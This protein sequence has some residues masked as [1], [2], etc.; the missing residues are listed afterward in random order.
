MNLVVDASAILAILFDEPDAELHLSK[1]LTAAKAW[2]SPVNWWEVQARMHSKYGAVG[3]AKSASWMESMGIVVEP[4]TLPQAKIA[5]AAFAKYHGRPAKL[6]MGDCFAYALAQ[7]KKVPLLYK[8]NDFP[9]TDV[10]PA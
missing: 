8:G 2:M 10:L 4:I 3:E 9:H 1:L 6:N 7:E 5:L